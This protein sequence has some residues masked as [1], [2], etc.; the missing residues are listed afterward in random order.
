MC[1]TN[2]PNEGAFGRTDGSGRPVTE[3]ISEIHEGDP[4]L[5]RGWPLRYW[6]LEPFDQGRSDWQIRYAS[7]F[8]HRGTFSETISAATDR[9]L[10]RQAMSSSMPARAGSFNSG[11]DER[12]GARSHRRRSLEGIEPMTCVPL[13]R[14]DRPGVPIPNVEGIDP[15]GPAS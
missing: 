10:T 11:S 8:E 12:R 3:L 5:R 7:V 2:S 9:V 13:V 4:S 1:R 14:A 6:G 15:R